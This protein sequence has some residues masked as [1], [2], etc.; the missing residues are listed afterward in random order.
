MWIPLL[1]IYYR[2]HF[3]LQIFFFLRIRAIS[4]KYGV[5]QHTQTHPPTQ[6]RL[7]SHNTF[8]LQMNQFREQRG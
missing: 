1:Q 6:H 2:L 8:L 7:Y 5:T 3:E 4:Q